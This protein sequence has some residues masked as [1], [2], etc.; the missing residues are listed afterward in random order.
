MEKIID[1]LVF[2]T[3]KKSHLKQTIKEIISMVNETI[4]GE[5]WFNETDKVSYADGDVG[6]MNHEVH[7]LETLRRQVSM[8]SESILQD[9]TKLLTLA[10]VK[11]T[12]FIISGMN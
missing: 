3:I 5:R 2:E 9:M 8:L 12:Y 1:F 7:V 11:M 4:K 6:D 10:I